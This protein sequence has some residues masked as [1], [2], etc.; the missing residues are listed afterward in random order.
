MNRPKD[1]ARTGFCCLNLK[2]VL[3]NGE[4]EVKFGKILSNGLD[5]MKNEYWQHPSN[6]N[7]P[8]IALTTAAKKGEGQPFI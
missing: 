7:N 3:Y 2:I 1:L 5:V 4:I 6:G 8:E